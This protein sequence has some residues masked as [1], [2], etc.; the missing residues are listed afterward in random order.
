MIEDLTDHMS[1]PFI[2]INKSLY[3]QKIVRNSQ[4]KAELKPESSF[5]NAGLLQEIER[6]MGTQG[7]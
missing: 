4:N 1:R 6:H 3:I 5:L 2:F 7:G